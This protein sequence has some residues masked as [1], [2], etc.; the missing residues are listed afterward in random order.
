MVGCAQAASAA[1]A[2]SRVEIRRTP[3]ARAADASTHEDR[4]PPTDDTATL[5]HTPPALVRAQP[6]RD[7]GRPM[8]VTTIHLG[9]VNGAWRHISRCRD[10]GER[11]RLVQ[12]PSNWRM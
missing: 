1:A 10:A 11:A 5:P 3:P 4:L 12:L 6:W 7:H 8:S 9:L 2:R